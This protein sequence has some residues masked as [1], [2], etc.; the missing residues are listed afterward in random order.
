MNQLFR[1]CKGRSQRSPTENMME[2]DSAPVF[3]IIDGFSEPQ[4]NIPQGHLMTEP[5]K[6]LM[7]WLMDR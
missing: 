6:W 1:K 4:G 2:G 3:W 7:N 5:A